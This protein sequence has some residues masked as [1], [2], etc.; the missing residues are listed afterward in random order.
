[1]FN[2]YEVKNLLSCDK[3]FQIL[4]F[5]YIIADKILWGGECDPV[6]LAE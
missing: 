6:L 1:M 4:S 3:Q 2:S 5:T